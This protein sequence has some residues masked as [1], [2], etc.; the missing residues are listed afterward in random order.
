M[1][2]IIKRLLCSVKMSF[3]AIMLTIFL[4][5][6][7][8]CISPSYDSDSSSSLK[9]TTEIS[10]TQ[11][12]DVAIG[13]LSDPVLSANFVKACGEIGLDPGKII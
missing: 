5:L 2:G 3:V 10:T 4:S 1:K 12:T 11:K 6:C 8:A 13:D 9:A 7:S